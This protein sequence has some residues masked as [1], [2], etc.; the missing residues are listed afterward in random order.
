[1][2]DFDPLRE[3][4]PDWDMDTVRRP[5][6]I[7]A[8]PVIDGKNLRGRRVIVGLPG[9]GWRAD[10]RADGPVIQGSRTYIPVL[11]EQEWYRAEVEQTEVFAPL[12]P[13]ERVWAEMV[14]ISTDGPEV[15]NDL[16]SRLVSLDAPPRQIPIPAG[17]AHRLYGRRVVQMAGPNE[18]AAVEF[19]NLRAVTE[20]HTTAEGD[21]CVRVAAELDW[22]RWAWSGQP[23]KTRAVPVHLL[24]VE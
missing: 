6:P 3:G 10:L 4:L 18:K 22:Y 12:V 1:V 24:W 16:V 2:T 19:R 23:P 13:V 8:I 14:S 11:P 5:A 9:L 7:E 21:I 17:E 20:P 15:P